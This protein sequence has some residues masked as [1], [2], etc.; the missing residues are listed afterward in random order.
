MY[1][2]HRWAPGAPKL[3]GI[4]HDEN[5]GSLQA[6]IQAIN[7]TG[8]AVSIADIANS[9]DGASIVITLTDSRTFTVNAA[10]PQWRTP[11]PR[12]IGT[13]YH[14]RDTVIDQG[15]TYLVLADHVASTLVATDVA[16]GKAMQIAAAGKDREVF[17]GAH[18]PASAYPAFSIVSVTAGGVTTFYKNFIDVPS[19][20]AAP[21]AFPWGITSF[22]EVSDTMVRVTAENKLLSAVVAEIRAELADHEAR[23]TAL[24]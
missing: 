10:S 12:V 23:I 5:I 21:G 18:N 2:I 6:M 15:S 17:R 22:L 3:T 24:E 14:V 7:E 20:G 11:V 13:T 9:S 1:P 4:Q 16:A 8:A 19:G